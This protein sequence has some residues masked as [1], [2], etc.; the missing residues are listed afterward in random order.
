M[1]RNLLEIFNRYKPRAEFEELLRS[2]DTESIALRVDK[3]QRLIEASAAF[4]RVIPKRTLYEIEEEIRTAYDL[5]MVRLRPRYPTESFDT[6]RVPD[7]LIET[8]RRGIVANGFFNHCDYRYSGGVLTVEIPFSESGVNL[9]YD[10]KTPQ[11]MEEIVRE[12]FGISIKVVINR[13][14]NY[15]PSQYQSSIDA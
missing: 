7:L 12:E 10:A 13:M 9:I 4:P 5:K 6:E 1:S 3:P 2:A 8:N 15:D 14:E 11:L